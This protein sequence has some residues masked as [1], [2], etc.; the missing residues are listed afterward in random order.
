MCTVWKKAWTFYLTPC[1]FHG[2]NK[3]LIQ[4]WNEQNLSYEMYN[5]LMLSWNDVHVSVER[6]M[7]KPDVW[8]T[9]HISESFLSQRAERQNHTDDGHPFQHAVNGYRNRRKVMLITSKNRPFSS[10]RTTKN[11]SASGVYMGHILQMGF[12]NSCSHLSSVIWL[13]EDKP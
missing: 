12:L 6:V 5:I 8:I 11:R 3:K 13:H 2:N 10:F 9:T 7:K 4:D 1:A